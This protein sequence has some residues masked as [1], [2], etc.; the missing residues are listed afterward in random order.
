MLITDWRFWLG[1]HLPLS[2]N[3]MFS[4]FRSLKKN[5][6]SF[7]IRG[8]TTRVGAIRFSK[9]QIPYLA[10]FSD[11]TRWFWAKH[12]CLHLK[13]GW[14]QRGNSGI[15]KPGPCVCIFSFKKRIV[16]T[17]LT[18]I[19]WTSGGGGLN[20]SR[21]AQ[22]KTALCLCPARELPCY[23]CE[24][25]SPRHSSWSKPYRGRVWSRKH[26][27]DSPKWRT[28]KRQESVDH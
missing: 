16:G 23:K 10:C 4:G 7:N 13:L 21:P 2:S 17:W 24:T 1:L 25:S 28:R 20:H 14:P 8:T 5:N 9:P 27:L 6:I 15:F 22:H 3:R 26:T 19:I 18:C 11:R 12:D